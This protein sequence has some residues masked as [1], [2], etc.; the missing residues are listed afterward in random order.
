[1]ESST[2]KVA[3][4]QKPGKGWDREG[5]GQAGVGLGRR[6]FPGVDRKPYVTFGL[7]SHPVIPDSS[8]LTMGVGTVV[9][10]AAAGAQPVMAPGWPGKLGPQ[11]GVKLGSGMPPGCHVTPENFLP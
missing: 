6:K 2:G 8:W 5:A 4:V 9:L 7:C 11:F 10:G 1:M 3:W